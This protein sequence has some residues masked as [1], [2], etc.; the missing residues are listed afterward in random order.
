MI[1]EIPGAPLSSDA[2]DSPPCAR[3]FPHRRSDDR[4]QGER[5]RPALQPQGVRLDG[6]A[7]GNRQ[8]GGAA[9]REELHHRRRGRGSPARRLTDFEALRRRGAGEV[10]YAFDLIELDGDDLRSLPIETRNVG[11]PLRSKGLWLVTRKHGYN[12]ARPKASKRRA[13]LTAWQ[14][15]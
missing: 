13:A 3:C 14:I 9:E 15:V 6:A 12:V 5:E 4:P 11:D 7:A 10:L 1:W 8:G 2:G